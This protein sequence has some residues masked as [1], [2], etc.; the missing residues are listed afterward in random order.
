MFNG[1]AKAAPLASWLGCIVQGM[2][3][4]Q[5]RRV[6][7]AVREVEWRTPNN[8][9]MRLAEHKTNVVPITTPS[10]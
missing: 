7:A 1:H 5:R 9:V 4:E 10:K 8:Q 3:G 2:R 6:F